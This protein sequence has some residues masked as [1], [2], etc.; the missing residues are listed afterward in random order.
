MSRSHNLKLVIIFILKF[1]SDNGVV[2][3]NFSGDNVKVQESSRLSVSQYLPES[4]NIPDSGKEIQSHILNN[5]SQNK[6]SLLKTIEKANCEDTVL[7]KKDATPLQSHTDSQ[8]KNNLP[9]SEELNPSNEINIENNYVHTAHSLVGI[10]ED[11]DLKTTQSIMSLAMTITQDD[12]NY[13]FDDEFEKLT[14]NLN[15]VNCN[16]KIE[17][18]NHVVEENGDQNTDPNKLEEEYKI[19]N[20]LKLL[21]SLVNIEHSKLEVQKNLTE[22]ELPKSNPESNEEKSG[23]ISSHKSSRKKESQKSK[24][25]LH[26]SSDG[27]EW[28]PEEKKKQKHHYSKHKNKSTKQD[29][30]NR[31]SKKKHRKLKNGNNLVN[32]FLN[33]S[34]EIQDDQNIS[35]VVHGSKSSSIEKTETVISTATS[36]NTLNTTNSITIT[37]PSEKAKSD[38]PTVDLKTYSDN[39]ENILVHK[40]ENFQSTN[41]NDC[42]HSTSSIASISTCKDEEHLKNKPSNNPSSVMKSIDYKKL[43]EMDRKS[44]FSPDIIISTKPIKDSINDLI[45]ENNQVKKTDNFI[46]DE[47]LKVKRC[48]E[49][50]NHSSSAKKI[51][52][53]HHNVLKVKISN[54][55]TKI[56]HPSQP[57]P[58]ND[59]SS[60]NQKLTNSS[61]TEKHNKFKKLK[62]HESDVKPKINTDNVKDN[63]LSSIERL[64]N[65]ETNNEDPSKSQQ[66]NLKQII[67]NEKSSADYSENNCMPEW[68][69]IKCVTYNIKPLYVVIDPNMRY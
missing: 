40:K 59:S 62:V 44:L 18:K 6:E 56:T 50:I 19:N 12:M 41:L 29:H 25:K 38:L 32:L 35:L 64:E 61:T 63:N 66:L 49:K 15:K 36:I 1:V 22:K 27:E 24:K 10:E 45:K 57:V 42:D 16:S 5:N 2:K 53:N 48:K 69:K 54:D 55:K 34:I 26:K 13:K 43:Y 51:K 31:L 7:N 23:R 68:L 11:D 28:I 39:V 8:K 4:N 47:K 21:E 67:E 65:K 14:N 37:L 3:Q 52:S 9:V 17:T 33:S 46:S 20:S 60:S 30:K 58:N